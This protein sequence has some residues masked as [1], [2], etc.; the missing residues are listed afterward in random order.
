MKKKGNIKYLNRTKDTAEDRNTK[1]TR[2]QYESPTQRKVRLA[3]M[4]QYSNS[5]TQ[6]YT[7]E[8]REARLSK[9]RKYD[10]SKRQNETTE[11]ARLAKER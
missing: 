7:T 2:R 1:K 10:N 6:N 3:K 9:V 4:R 5:K 11:E 8:Q